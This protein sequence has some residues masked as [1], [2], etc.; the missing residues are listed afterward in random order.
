MYTLLLEHKQSRRDIALKTS[1]D[2]LGKNTAW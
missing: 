1:I 2:K